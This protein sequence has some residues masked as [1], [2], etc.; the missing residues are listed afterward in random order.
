MGGSLTRPSRVNTFDAAERFRQL[1]NRLGPADAAELE[2][3]FD[4]LPPLRCEQMLGPWRG[5][6]FDTGHPGSRSLRKL[7]WHGKTFHS[8]TEVDPLVCRDEDGNLFSD[9]KTMGG[10]ASLWM[11]EYRGKLSATMIYDGKPVLDHFRRVDER[12][13]MGVMNGKGVLHDGRPYFFYLERSGR[14]EARAS[15][16]YG[17]GRDH[18]AP[19]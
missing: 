18:A 10:G 11:V 7:R 15:R 3:I 1:R 2:T 19:V 13:L 5:G 9:L 12:T 17:P 4:A 16:P 8:L 6:D 14:I